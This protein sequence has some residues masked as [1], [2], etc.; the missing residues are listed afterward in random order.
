[1]YF[2]LE[3]V[4][5][6]CHVRLLEGFVGLFFQQTILPPSGGEGSNITLST[7]QTQVT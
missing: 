2:L 7:K 3:K 5:F 1:M 4:D 6:H